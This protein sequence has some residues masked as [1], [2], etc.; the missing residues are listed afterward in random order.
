MISPRVRLASL[1]V[2]VAVSLAA[3]APPLW[4]LD[5]GVF[6]VGAGKE[7]ITPA[8]ET[9]E[10]QNGNNRFDAGEPYKDRNGNGKRDVVYI[11]G[12]GRNREA[13]GVHDDLW[14]R[15]MAVKRGDAT[16][17]MVALDLIG[18]PSDLCIRIKGEIVKRFGLPWNRVLIASTHTHHGPDA[19]GMWGRTLL[20]SGADPAYLD[21]LPGK[22][23]AAVKQALDSLRPARFKVASVS[24]PTVVKDIH[25]PHV[26]DPEL[27][28][29]QAVGLD[30][31]SVAVV[32][33]FASHPEMVDE[34]QHLISCDYPHFLRERLEKNLGGGIALFFAGALGGMQTPNAPG[35]TFDDCRQI[36]EFK[37]DQAAA[38]LGAAPLSRSNTF[39][40]Y[41]HRVALPLGNQMFALG[42]AIR[43]RGATAIFESLPKDAQGRRLVP[44]EFMLIRLSDTEFITNPGE[45]YPELGFK[46]KEK[47]RGKV[48]FNV[49]LCFG[50]IGYI[51][52]PEIWNP[53]GYEESMSFGVDT[54]PTLLEALLAAIS[55]DEVALAKSE[56]DLLP[57]IPQTLLPDGVRG[58]PAAQ[59]ESGDE[60]F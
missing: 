41:S 28:L 7:A 29:L 59:P 38:A 12:Y 51:V 35:N 21:T 2:L 43:G 13:F 14:A 24:L 34:K 5:D 23:A 53:K 50:E 31:K 58:A 30:G 46:L 60:E 32:A 11:A 4:A 39:F 27:S 49:G 36:G 20:E 55:A 25:A 54:A 6:L 45:M 44:C 52:P 42:M 3:V 19:I 22:V 15:A 48:K 10:D 16:L 8:V 57:L 9:F 37:A 56:Q 17:V 1:I 26:T 40:V 47:M 18:A 33:N